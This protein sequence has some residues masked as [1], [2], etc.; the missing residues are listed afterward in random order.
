MMEFGSR[1]RVTLFGTSHGPQVGA[2][3]EGVPR[4]A[5]IDL[6]RIQ[7]ELD[8][9][10]PIGRRLAT[11]RRESDRLI[12][13]EGIVGGAA[14]GRRIRIH[15]ANEDARSGPYE[16]LRGTPRPGHADYPASVRFGTSVDLSG[17]G[18]FSGRMTVGLVAAGAIA[19]DLIEPKG[20]EVLSFTRS[21]GGI[22]DALVPDESFAQLRAR[23][24]A[25]EVG[26]IDPTQAAAMAKRIEEVR[27]DGD[28]VG[29]TIEGRAVGL[30]VG[31]GEPFF[32]SV[33]SEIAHLMFSIP[34]VKAIEFGAGFQVA[35][36]HGSEN[37]DPFYW[38]EDGVVSTR[39]NHAGGI[40][41][42]LST[43]RPL[44]FR[45]AIKPTASIPRPQ[46]TVDLIRRTSAT[47]VVKGRHDPCIV[48]RAVA[49][50]EAGTAI[51]LAD[52]CLRA[53]LLP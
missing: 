10:R 39:T 6:P 17:G 12:V 4:G 32:D 35:R 2:I 37:N 13:D 22:D 42:G 34:A 26:A 8:R 21:I 38:D 23:R 48:P 36:L 44:I 40:L 52:L 16:E 25:N 45:L 51:V 1:F 11:R 50:V 15:V 29:G 9:R 20:I 19:R 33:E 47:I 53:G 14:S 7:A 30:P 24:D 18:I 31:L 49:V 28:S 27:R 41:G 3:I 5:S 46:E 43:G